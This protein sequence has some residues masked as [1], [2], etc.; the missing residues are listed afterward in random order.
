M[1][2]EIQA[3]LDKANEF[4]EKARDALPRW[5][6]EAGRAAYLAAF[7][8]AQAFVFFETGGIAKTHSGVRGLFGQLVRDDPR[9]DDELRAFLGRAYNF[10]MTA[11]YE[12]GVPADIEPEQAEAAIRIAI[13]FIDRIAGA[14]EGRPAGD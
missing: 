14:I 10:K 9:F 4:I 6:D 5:P 7:H 13:R 11:D 8:A 3:F 12:T 1:T 2:P